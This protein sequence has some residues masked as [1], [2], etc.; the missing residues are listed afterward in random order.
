MGEGGNFLSLLSERPVQ[1]QQTDEFGLPGVL[2]PSDFPGGPGGPG[3]DLDPVQALAEFQASELLK[4]KQFVEEIDETLG[5]FL[6]RARAIIDQ[7]PAQQSTLQLIFEGR[8]GRRR[9]ER[10]QMQTQSRQLDAILPTVNTLFEQKR[11]V[12]APGGVA[13]EEF[14]AMQQRALQFQRH[15]EVLKLELFLEEMQ[16]GFTRNP[17]WEI[18]KLNFITGKGALQTP[19]GSDIDILDV[20]RAINTGQSLDT[21]EE[22]RAALAGQPSHVIQAGVNALR[23]RQREDRIE[24]AEKRDFI[25]GRFKT[26]LEMRNAV[27]KQLKLQEE[28]PEFEMAEDVIPGK[29]KLFPDRRLRSFVK[30]DMS[31]RIR[32]AVNSLNI[33]LDKAADVYPILMPQVDPNANADVENNMNDINSIFEE[34][35]KAEK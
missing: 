33:P 22:V 7:P 31:E 24:A 2:E 32:R 6:D 12:L 11:A 28:D 23:R 26:E 9:R 34:R 18:T 25:P 13:S 19:E 5:T 4:K 29:N 3:G 15:Q 16:P 21:E 35:D 30:M 8:S 14:R 27:D 1:E 17:E 10:L 20:N